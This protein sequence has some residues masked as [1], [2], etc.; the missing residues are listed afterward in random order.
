MKPQESVFVVF[1]ESSANY[2]KVTYKDQPDLPK[3]SFLVNDKAN[4]VMQ[5]QKN[6]NYSAVINNTDD[7]N[8]NVKDIPNPIEIKG[9]WQIDFREED[10][11]KA[12]IKT[13]S[14]F[15]WTTSKVEEIKHYSG[16]AI[17]KIDF[18]VGK[19]I[20]K[21]DR[22]FE[23]DLGTVNVIAKV[24][25]NGKDMGVSWIAPYTLDVT[26]ALKEGT[27][28]L[29]IQITN[30]W[31]NRVIGGEKLPNQTGYDIRRGQPGFGDENFRGDDVKMPEWFR[32][33]QPLPEGPRK[34]FS[35]YGFQKANDPLL[36]SGL[37][38]P[39]KIVT[40]KIIT[41]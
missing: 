2:P 34:T 15:D 10:F 27:N 6:G 3:P 29:E 35:A 26:S 41:K 16:T 25:L 4:L 24:I 28:T 14:L 37:L 11:Y 33:N 31:T 38:G 39:V 12:T 36:P 5:V 30:Q 7:W 13:D 23:L 18:K 8:V 21:S 19:K 17:Y 20:L 9:N 1:R 22:K 40:N 32:K